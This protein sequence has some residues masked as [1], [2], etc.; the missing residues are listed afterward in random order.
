MTEVRWTEQAADDLAAILEFIRRDSPAYAHLVVGRL[1]GAVGQL[2]DFPDSGRVVPERAQPTLRELIRPPSGMLY[3]LGR[4]PGVYRERS[5][6][7]RVFGELYAFPTETTDRS[8]E[9]LD[10]H[11][12]PEF[13]RKRVYVTLRGGRRRAAWTYLLRS[14]PGKS[15]R[16][17]TSGRYQLKR[18]AA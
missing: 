2:R 6:G 18:G 8:L 9:T 13:T 14:Q 11:E 15:A 1:Y 5:A 7:N 4:Y 3:D 10:R 16:P 17:V 12:G